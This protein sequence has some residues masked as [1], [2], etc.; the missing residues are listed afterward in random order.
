MTSTQMEDSGEWTDTDESPRDE[1]DEDIPVTSTTMTLL[2][3]WLPPR[4]WILNPL[5][6]LRVTVAPSC[7][8][9]TVLCET[10]S[11]PKFHRFAATMPITRAQVPHTPAA[12]IRAN[13]Q[14]VAM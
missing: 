1:D 7:R 8:S 11:D 6:V 9:L 14:F 3:S 10:S 4:T 2:V 5:M 12:H 13:M